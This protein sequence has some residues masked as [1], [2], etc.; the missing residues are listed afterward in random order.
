MPWNYRRM[1]HKD[2]E[3]YVFSVH[4]VYYDNE[5]K[6]NNWSAMPSGI[7]SDTEDFT[8]VMVQMTRCFMEPILDGETGEELTE[9]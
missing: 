5:G 6:V 7:I 1:R 9:A 4:E 3:D 2:G 8:Q